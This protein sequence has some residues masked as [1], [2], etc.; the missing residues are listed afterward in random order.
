MRKGTWVIMVICTIL[1]IS[2]PTSG[3]VSKQE[4]IPECV[5]KLMDC[6]EEHV[7]SK[8]PKFDRYAPEYDVKEYVCCPLMQQIV[9]PQKQ[10][11]CSSVATPFFFSLLDDTLGR[12]AKDESNNLT[13]V[14]T[15]CDVVDASVPSL[16][17]FCKDSSAVL[18]SN[19]NIVETSTNAAEGRKYSTF[20]TLLSTLIS[21]VIHLYKM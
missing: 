3:E 5:Q 12:P 9:I 8:D 4:E 6:V 18:L 11:V 1:Y 10:C 2:K 20:A 17:D 13:R 21:L 15:L 16:G 14:L 19:E 7:D